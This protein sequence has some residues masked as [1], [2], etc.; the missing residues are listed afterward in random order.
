MRLLTA[1]TLTA[2]LAGCGGDEPEPAPTQQPEESAQP[3]AAVPAAPRPEPDTAAEPESEAPEPGS[4]VGDRR[5]YTVQ[6]AAFVNAVTARE[7]TERL[8]D[9][10]IPVWTSTA[11][12]DGRM[13][14][15]LRLGALPELSEARRLADMIRARYHWPVWVAPL[16]PSDRLPLNAVQRTREAARSGR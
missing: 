1:L 15:R 4:R 11:R 14:H 13:F 8:Q 6:V 10:E 2:L 9:Q 16:T 7:W 3:P 5:I 12:V